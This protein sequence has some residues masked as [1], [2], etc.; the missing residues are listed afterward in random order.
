MPKYILLLIPALLLGACTEK[1]P[2]PDPQPPVDTL[3]PPTDPPVPPTDTL[4]RPPKKFPNG[5]T[6]PVLP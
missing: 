4:I 3:A 2:A 6:V 5:D 1:A